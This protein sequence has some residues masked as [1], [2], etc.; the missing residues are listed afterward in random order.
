MKRLLI[1]PIAIIVWSCVAGS[2]KPPAVPTPPQAP[3]ITPATFEA[4]ARVAKDA[5]SYAE[6]VLASVW[7]YAKSVGCPI[8]SPATTL[9]FRINGGGPDNETG[10]R[11]QLDDAASED[12]FD[13]ARDSLIRDIQVF[14]IAPL[15]A[16]S[17]DLSPQWAAIEAQLTP[18]K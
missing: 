18:I 2:V 13:F 10:R 8:D 1:I 9:K 12:A 15:K 6:E 11:H 3:V 4:R 14:A 5:A 7:D 16:C 17:T